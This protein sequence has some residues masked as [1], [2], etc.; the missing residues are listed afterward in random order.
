MTAANFNRDK[1]KIFDCEYVGKFALLRAPL[2]GSGTMEDVLFPSG[3]AGNKMCT[4]QCG[5]HFTGADK[6]FKGDIT[7]P[8]SLIPSL[9]KFRVFS[10]VTR[11]GKLHAFLT[12][13]SPF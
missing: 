5:T 13:V 7:S 11:D 2:W 3:R 1:V 12:T 4:A 6:N 10:I 8:F 9:L